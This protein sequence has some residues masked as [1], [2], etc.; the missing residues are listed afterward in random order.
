MNILVA[1]G[2]T[3]GD[4]FPAVAVVEQLEKLLGN[5]LSVVFVGNPNRIEATKVPELG[6]RFEPIS[7]TGFQG[8]FH[9]STPTL[10][11]R[12]F[13]SI[14]KVRSLCKWHRIDAILCGGTYISYPAGIAAQQLGIPM[15]L[16]EPNV[17]PGKTN[18][19]LAKRATSIILAFEQSKR[20][21]PSEI[22]HKMLA[23]GNPVR[24]S[25]LLTLPEQAS[26]AA[27]K[28]F[29]LEP[30]KPTVF[31]FGGSLGARSINQAVEASLNDFAPHN[32]QLLWQTGNNYTPPGNLPD[33]VVVKT[34]I[35]DMASAYAAADLVICR[36]GGGTVA[37]LANVGKPALLIP[38]PS[39]ANNEQYYN[40][41][42]LE[43]HG[44]ARLLGNDTLKQ[45]LFET[46][47]ELIHNPS[48]LLEM[49]VAAK[50]LAKPNAAFQAATEL[51]KIVSK[52]NT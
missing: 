44:A 11:L 29:G 30:Y 2:G 1:A 26:S 43:E 25:M 31:V 33:G 52:A 3:G 8:I 28:Q 34:F 41:K 40:A 37:E 5:N 38:L 22:H 12:I 16:L 20:F 50:K 48:V 23:V 21:F 19:L 42:T 7:V 15:M 9:K 10:P 17:L 35:D 51:I 45:T 39:A 4:L 14:V 47:L 13:R 18:R 49:S 46:I 6:Y 24:E 27:R 32:M 36:S